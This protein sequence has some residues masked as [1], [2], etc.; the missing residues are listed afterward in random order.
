MPTALLQKTQLVRSVSAFFCVM[1]TETKVQRLGSNRCCLIAIIAYLI[2]NYSKL[3]V[4]RNSVEKH[5]LWNTQNSTRNPRQ[6]LSILQRNLGEYRETQGP[7]L[8]AEVFS[9]LWDDRMH[10]GIHLATA[11]PG[12]SGSIESSATATSKVRQT[13]GR[14]GPLGAPC[15]EVISQ[16]YSLRQ[17]IVFNTCYCYDK[18]RQHK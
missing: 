17:P 16:R 3:A 9:S 1:T 14:S 12:T 5:R 4:K 2:L 8:G 6:L 15:P 7:W 11:T 10:F 18:D 13:S